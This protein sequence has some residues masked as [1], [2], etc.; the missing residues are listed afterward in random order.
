MA[1]PAN[2]P[3]ALASGWVRG[4]TVNFEVRLQRPSQLFLADVVLPTSD[5]YSEYTVRPAM[6][7]IRQR[8]WETRRADGI[9]VVVLLPEHEIHP[10]LDDELT[11]AARR[12]SEVVDE[13]RRIDWRMVSAVGRRLTLSVVVL[14][15]VRWPPAS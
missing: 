1:V 13:S 7:T 8:I 14:Y 3:G 2:E 5:Y 15:V 9:D 10:G 4:F 11:V 6:E 12:W